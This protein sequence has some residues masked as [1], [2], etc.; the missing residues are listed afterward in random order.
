MNEH[1]AATT[2]QGNPLTLVGDMV[3][4][5][6]NAPDVELTDN[7]LKPFKLSSLR[8]KVCILSSVPSLDTPVCDTETR[9]FNQEV[10]NLGSGVH[11]VTVS[12]DLPFAQTRWCGAA[13]IKSVQTLSDYRAA[14]FGTSYGLLIKELHLLARA[15][16]V[17]DREGAVRYVQLVKEMTQEPNYDEVI[18]EVKKLL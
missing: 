9:R 17:V 6:Q 3:Q 8:G 4:V 10:E 16:M 13:G 11:C 18:N 5:G 12:M 1:S 2:F 7:E 15:V 14:T